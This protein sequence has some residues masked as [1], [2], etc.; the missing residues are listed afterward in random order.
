MPEPTK[1]PSLP[2]ISRDDCVVDFLTVLVDLSDAAK[3][4]GKSV[5]LPEDIH[6]ACAAA[7]MSTNVGGGKAADK[8]LSG[9][10]LANKKDKAI[11]TAYDAYINTGVK[12]SEAKRKRA[13]LES[14]ICDIADVKTIGKIS[15]TEFFSRY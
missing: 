8:P 12:E 9:A 2:N 10:S 1:K 13:S 4:L 15:P 6:K 11:Q 14:R 3:K 7:G 5:L